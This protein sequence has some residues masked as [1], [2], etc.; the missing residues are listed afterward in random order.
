MTAITLGY[1]IAVNI[2]ADNL[3]AQKAL[4]ERFQRWCDEHALKAKVRQGS[5]A[6]FGDVRGQ[7]DRLS[8]TVTFETTKDAERFHTDAGEKT[9]TYCD[10][11]SLW[12]S[13]MTPPV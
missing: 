2:R 12:E 10:P 1:D 13:L 11:P 8:I 7:Y 3:A 9:L 4:Y 5:T 6:S